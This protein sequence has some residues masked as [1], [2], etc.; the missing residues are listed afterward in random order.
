[1]LVI[2]YKIEMFTLRKLY[3]YGK[4]RLMFISAFIGTPIHELSH[5]FFCVLAGHKITKI[6]LL[7]FNG[8]DTLGY[9][10]HTYNPRNI[11]HQCGRFFIGIAPLIGGL[12]A[13][14]FISLTLFPSID[15]IGFIEDINQNILLVD[16]LNDYSSLL[17]QSSL[18]AM[19]LH[20]RLFFQDHLKYTIWFFVVASIVSHIT[21]SSADLKGASTGAIFLSIIIALIWFFFGIDTINNLFLPMISLLLSVLTAFFLIVILFN[22]LLVIIAK[23]G[24]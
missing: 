15:F 19:N 23:M 16:S 1:M 8:S 17:F 5:A 20:L 24:H 11:F 9:V 21:P 12:G 2:Q 18:D 7:Q 22:L 13:V 6:K 14:V 4:P 10:K 3:S